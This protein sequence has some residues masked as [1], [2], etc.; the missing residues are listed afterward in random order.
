[1][2]AGA[3]LL[4]DAIV[5]DRAAFYHAPACPGVEK[6]GDRIAVG[7]PHW[8]PGAALRSGGEPPCEVVAGMTRE[9]ERTCPVT[10]EMDASEY[11]V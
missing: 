3:E 10:L 2:V 11:G 7:R 1:M 8:Q 5:R 4:E 9:G 6:V